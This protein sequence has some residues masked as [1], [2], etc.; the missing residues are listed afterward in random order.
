MEPAAEDMAIMEDMEVSMADMMTTMMIRK[1][2]LV[3]MEG[4]GNMEEIMG[5][6]MEEK[7]MVGM[8]I[9]VKVDMDM[10]AA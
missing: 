10:G 1:R 9:M 7:G 4:M 3:D 8:E 6:I 5:M 2:G